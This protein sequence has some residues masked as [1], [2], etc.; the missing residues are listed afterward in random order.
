MTRLRRLFRYRYQNAFGY[1][2]DSKI[3][4][5]LTADRRGLLIDF[6]WAAKLVERANRF[7]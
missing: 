5:I 2:G 6:D 4:M 3:K 7:S 1:A